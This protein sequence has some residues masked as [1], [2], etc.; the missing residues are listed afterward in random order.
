MNHG[1]PP[2]HL[3]YP[4]RHH[5]PWQPTSSAPTPHLAVGHSPLTSL[6]IPRSQHFAH[7]TSLTTPRSQHLSNNYDLNCK[8]LAHCPL[9]HAENVTTMQIPATMALAQPCHRISYITYAYCNSPAA[10]TLIEYYAA[11]RHVIPW[12][13][14]A[15]K[16]GTI[17]KEKSRIKRS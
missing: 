1:P 15:I 10:P 2:S 17:S 5:R 7:H 12:V 4:P 14:T 8:T 13:Y 9:M 6:T 16:S 11:P 3:N